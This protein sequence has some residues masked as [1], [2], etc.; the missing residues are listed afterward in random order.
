MKANFILILCVFVVFA[1]GAQTSLKLNLTQGKEYRQNSDMKMAMTQSFGGQTMDVVV[2][3]KGKMKYLVKSVTPAAYDIDVMY[4]SM[5]MEMEMPQATMK[6]SSENPAADDMVSQVLSGMTNKPFQV[7]LSKSGKVL[8][9]KNIETLLSTAFDKLPNISEAQKSQIKGQLEQRY[10]EKAFASTFEMMFSIFPDKPVKTGEKWTTQ[11]KLNSGV[12]A[13]INTTF[14]YVE[15]GADFWK[16][17]GD[18]KITAEENGE[19]INSNGMDMKFNMN[20]TMISNIKVDKKTGWILEA[21]ITQD[22]TGE[23]QIKGNAQMPDGLTIPMTMKTE[24]VN[25]GN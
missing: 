9:V 13:N 22:I 6:F 14:E 24:I 23:A 20:G 7:Q 2:A 11:S 3:V 16:I 19:Y 8:G 5:T 12:T 15:E 18:S 17:H 25:T 1:S 10:G 4:E 21:K